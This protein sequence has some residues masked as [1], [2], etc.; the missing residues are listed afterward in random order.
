MKQLVIIVLLAVFLFAS[1]ATNTLLTHL[2][3]KQ[4]KTNKLLRLDPAAV[5]LY[6]LENERLKTNSKPV[7]RIVFFGDS[8]IFEWKNLP[9]ISGFQSINR[10]IPAQTT[11]QALMRI[12]GDLIELSPEIAVIQLGVNDLNSLGLTLE[13][14]EKIIRRSQKNL[15]QIVKILSQH[16]IKI[17]WLS[18]F[19]VG[20]V[21]FY[22]Y[23]VWSHQTR[24]AVKSV[25]QQLST[26]ET[27]GFNFVNCDEIFLSG[28]S[29]KQ[30]VI[31]P[32]YSRDM[33]HLNNNGYQA[34]NDHLKPILSNLAQ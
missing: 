6:R 15:E 27:D 33:L 1:L 21:P 23:Y 5:Q 25:N 30:P 8:R 26:V 24:K 34:L 12:Y 9:E 4:Y 2:V 28:N 17:V 18:I 14:S 11:S 7:K 13:N 10:G 31:K 3:F 20:E 29:D 16:H 32:E 19:P 22:H